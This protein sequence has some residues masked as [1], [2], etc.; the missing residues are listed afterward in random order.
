MSR[1]KRKPTR[2]VAVPIAQLHAIVERT[3][4]ALSQDEHATLQAAV[5]TLARLTEELETQTTT[6]ERVRR[7]IFGARNE[8]TDTV[9]GTE[10]KDP[11]EDASAPNPSAAG[12]ASAATDGDT[13]PKPPRSGHGRNGA[14]KYPGAPRIP[15][16]HANLKHGDPCPESGCTGRLY[17]Q[18]QEPA[19]LVRVTGVAPL[20]AQVYTLERLRC[21]LCGTVLTAEPP[22]GWARRN[23]MRA[24]RP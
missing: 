21:G 11:S 15:V 8:T 9:L 16:A 3:R 10:Q 7:L 5:D 17:V 23:T 14:E 1:R 4:N 18:R 12:E 19:L 24:P 2:R 13:P 22:P 6:L 20:Q